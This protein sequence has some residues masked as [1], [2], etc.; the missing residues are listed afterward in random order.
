[1]SLLARIGWTAAVLLVLGAAVGMGVLLPVHREAFRQ[2]GDDLL[3]ATERDLGDIATA[4]VRDAVAFSAHAAHAADEQRA[5]ALSDL[6]FELYTDARG[7]L[8]T[9][10]LREV[11]RGI[12][13]DASTARAEKHAAVRQEI[14]ER[15]R[16][17]AAVRLEALRRAQS[18]GAQ[19]R[20]EAAGRRTLAAWGGLILILFATGAFLLDRLVVRPI[21]MVTDVVTRFGEGE[22]DA[23]L[24][25]AGGGEISALAGA[26]NHTADRVVAAEAENRELRGRLE[27]KVEER[28]AALVR[29]ARAAT[30]G[31]LARGV[32]H[33]FNNVLGG[34]LGCAESALHEDPPAAVAEALAMIR[35]TAGRGVGM[36]NAILRATRAEPDRAPCVVGALFDEALA[37]VRP[38]DGIRVERRLEALTLE[39]DPA[40]LR[41]VLANLV[42][43]A[44][45]AMEGS[46]VLTLTAARRGGEVVL[47]V[48]DTGPGIDPSVREILFEPFVTTH[49][50]RREGTGLGLFLAERLVAAH[51]GRVAVQSA[52]G[53]GAAFAVHLPSARNS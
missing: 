20:A 25:A 33:E 10:R 48:G 8:A 45:E 9:E 16:T 44:V 11:L 41:Q 26:F 40:M 28:T 46:G 4:L 47:E 50:G 14:L 38:P 19:Q 15:T 37:E 34:V 49:R 7:R 24:E 36:T 12:L 32:A 53:Q 39:A 3:Q 35:K 13:A 27:Q 6:P 5:L 2:H 21:G 18:R 42:R 22:R 30:A 43:N 51:G 29:A 23:R 31:T 17:D 52:P 1:M